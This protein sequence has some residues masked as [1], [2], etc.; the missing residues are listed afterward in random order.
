MPNLLNRFRGVLRSLSNLLFPPVCPACGKISGSFIDGELCESCRAEFAEEF[1]T[2][3]PHCKSTP[4]ACRCVPDLLGNDSDRSPFTEIKPLTFSGYYTGF[5][6]DS[7]ISSLV[8]NLKRD[9]TSGAGVF[10]ARMMVQTASRNL[11]LWKIP[12]ENIILTYIPRSDAAYDEHCFDHMDIVATH[13][14]RMLGCR[15]AKLLSRHGGTAQKKLGLTERE[16]NA[17]ETISI[18][19]KAAEMIKDSKILILDDIITTGSTMKTAVSRL[20]LAGAELIIP[21]S[22][23]ISKTKKK[24]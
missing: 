8:F 11:A 7:K 9:H 10:F 3:C 22:A 4:E 21:C 18:N 16:S 2:V 20:S 12:R 1:V 5:D 13:V 23:M 6:E 14:A 19:P 17:A 24:D 15:K